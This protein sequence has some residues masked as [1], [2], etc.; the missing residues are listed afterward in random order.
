MYSPPN[1]ENWKSKY[2]TLKFNEKYTRIYKEGFQAGKDM[3]LL[4]D[5]PYT[6]ENF[7]AYFWY[8]GQI[9][10]IEDNIDKVGI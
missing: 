4:V 1:K 5:N 9:D 6:N 3:V 7:E 10:Y 2:K 8:L